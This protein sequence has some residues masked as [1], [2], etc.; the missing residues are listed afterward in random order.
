MRIQ[1]A[2]V[3]P[4]VEEQAEAIIEK[5]DKYSGPREDLYIDEFYE[6]RARGYLANFRLFDAGV[7]LDHW[8]GARPDSVPARLM[9]ANIRERELNFQAAE[10]EYRERSGG[11][12]YKHRRKSEAAAD[13]ASVPVLTT[14]NPRPAFLDKE[15]RR[16]FL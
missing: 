13:G 2:V 12:H 8:V 9:R 1:C 16:L 14:A 3:S 4:E 7:T 15:G 6:A 11:L 10:R 5:A